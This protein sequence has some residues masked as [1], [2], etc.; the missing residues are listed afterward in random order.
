[1]DQHEETLAELEQKREEKLEEAQKHLETSKGT[2]PPESQ[3]KKLAP[4]EKKYSILEKDE[5]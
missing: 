2:P 3:F 5:L 4:N 1:M